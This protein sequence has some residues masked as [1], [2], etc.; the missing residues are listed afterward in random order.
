MGVVVET[1]LA[2]GFRAP[3][4][5]KAVA[6]RDFGVGPVHFGVQFPQPAEEM[7]GRYRSGEGRPGIHGGWWVGMHGKSFRER[8]IHATGVG[9]NSREYRIMA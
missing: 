9:K 2:T 7:A 3:L 5:V 1:G 8:A 6:L 4:A